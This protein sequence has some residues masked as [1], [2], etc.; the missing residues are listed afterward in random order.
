LS[1]GK[2]FYCSINALPKSLTHLSFGF[3]F[4]KKISDIPKMVLPINLTNVTLSFGPWFDTP[5]SNLSDK[6]TCINFGKNFKQNIDKDNLPKNLT[7]LF[8]NKVAQFNNSLDNLPENLTHL[9]LGR[10]TPVRLAHPKIFI[11][12]EMT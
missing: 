1:F 11:I 7:Q 6:I 9:T 8:F 10:Q 5:L 3:Y 2:N 12:F 4:N